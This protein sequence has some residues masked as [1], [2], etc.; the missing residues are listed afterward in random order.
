MYVELSLLLLSL[1]VFLM[2]AFTAPLL[3]Q[4]NKLVKGL[5][6]TQGMLQQR[7]PEILKNLDEAAVQ[8]KMTV[9][10]VNDQ[11]AIAAG[12]IKRVQAVAGVLMEVESILR[13]G[14]RLPFFVFLKNAG[15]F[16]KGVR[17]FVDVYSSSRRRIS[18]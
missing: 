3:Y 8:M 15:A 10:T 1:A 16:L 12:V 5:H 9:H 11:V 4:L 2:A 18:H 7:L 17:V 13:L 6:V 14:L